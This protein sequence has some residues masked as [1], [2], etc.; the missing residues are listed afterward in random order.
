MTLLFRDPLFQQHDTGPHPERASRLQWIDRYLDEAG[1]PAR[2]TVGAYT[3][4]TYAAL[5]AVHAPRQVRAVKKWLNSAASGP[6][7]RS[8]AT[9]GKA[10]AREAE[11]VR[12][13]RLNTA[14]N[15]TDRTFPRRARRRLPAT[16]SF[17]W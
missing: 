13:K 3:P 11:I 4:L 15:L 1:L 9:A 5:L 14:C 6:R 2:C 7:G 10:R 12:K 16:A 8:C 17:E